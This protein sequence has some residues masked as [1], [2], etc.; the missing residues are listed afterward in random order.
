[1]KNVIIFGAAGFLG[2]NLTPHLVHCGYTVTAIDKHEKNLRLLKHLN[3]QIQTQVADLSQQGTWR[4][5]CKNQDVLVDLHAQIASPNKQDFVQNNIKATQLMVDAAKL[6]KIP[7][8]VHISS[9]AVNSVRKDDYAATKKASEDIIQKSGIDFVS[10]RPSMMY[11]PFDNKNVGWLMSFA[12]K[13]PLFPMP[14]SGKYPR[15]PLFVQDMCA[16]IAALI[17]SQ[18]KNVMYN[19]NGKRIDFID[20]VKIILRIAKIP[21]PIVRLPIPIFLLGL[22]GYNFMKRKVVFTPDQIHSLISGDVF[23]DFDFTKAYKVPQTTF[24]DGMRLTITHK[25]AHTILER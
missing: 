5:C 10:L 1:M 20:M 14:G 19:I 25:H 18:P 12:K 22:K 23:E 11:G 15:Q 16:L 4:T 9:A 8:I 13:M 17:K 21:R 7:Y 2:Q 24:E 6:Y 3:P